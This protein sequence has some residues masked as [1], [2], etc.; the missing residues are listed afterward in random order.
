MT[1][2]QFDEFK[3]IAEKWNEKHDVCPSCGA[4]QHCG[5]GG[6]VPS[7]PMY[8]SYPSGP[9]YWGPYVTWTSGAPT[10]TMASGGCI[11]SGTVD[12]VR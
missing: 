7:Y 11:T 8:P 5:R 9:W 6:Y 1:K 10:I 4:C 2:E 12:Y 3:A